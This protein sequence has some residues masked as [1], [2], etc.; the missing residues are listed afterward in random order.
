MTK[1]EIKTAIDSKG[2]AYTRKSQ[3]PIWKEAFAEYNKT[4]GQKLNPSC[5]GCWTKI[6]E[7]LK[8]G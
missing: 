5:G 3:D 6:F 7:W 4:H 8:Q 2:L 1:Q